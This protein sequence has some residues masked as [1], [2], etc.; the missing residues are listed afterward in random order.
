MLPS[1]GECMDDWWY[2]KKIWIVALLLWV[3][4]VGAPAAAGTFDVAFAAGAALGA[5]VLSAL[6]VAISQAVLGLVRSMRAG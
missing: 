1:E 6:I 3:L 4:V 2:Q 5:V